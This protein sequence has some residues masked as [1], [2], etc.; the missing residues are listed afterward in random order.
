MWVQRG[1]E[2]VE[3]LVTDVQQNGLALAVRNPRNQGKKQQQKPT[4]VATQFLE[5]TFA[6]ANIDSI[7][8]VETVPVA[9]VGL[10]VKGLWSHIFDINL[11]LTHA[12]I[13]L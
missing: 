8:W 5:R 6:F 2:K 1:A 7:A 4:A 12:L 13:L 11:I 3:L 10:G 9:F